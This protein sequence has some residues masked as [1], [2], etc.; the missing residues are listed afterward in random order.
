MKQVYIKLAIVGPYNLFECQ[1]C[2]CLVTDKRVH[3]KSHD[4]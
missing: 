3:N 4:G 1:G 2:G